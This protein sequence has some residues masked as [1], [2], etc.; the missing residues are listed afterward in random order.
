VLVGPTTTFFDSDPFL[1]QRLVA[2]SPEDMG[3]IRTTVEALLAH[4]GAVA[5][6]IIQLG[7]KR[8]TLFA[9]MRKRLNG[10][11]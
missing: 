8:E 3:C 2:A 5:E 4:Y 1:R 9:E 11:R 10:T 6:G 7:L